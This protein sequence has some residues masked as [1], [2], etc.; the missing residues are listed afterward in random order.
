MRH[1][2]VMAQRTS[3]PIRVLLLLGNWTG[4]GAERVA[5]HLMKRLPP[6]WDVHL[7]L[8]HAG[9]AWLEEL[10]PA[11]VHMAPQAARRFRYD[12]PNTELF[13]CTTLLNGAL[14]G[15]RALRQM[16]R[17]IAPDVVVSFLK[18]TAIL[19]W[20]ALAGLRKRPGWIAREGNNIFAT[21]AQESPNRLVRTVSLG[22]TGMA[23][24][25]ADAV[26]TNAR[27]MA[28]D[29]TSRLRLDPARVHTIPNP[30]DAQ[31]IAAAA[32]QPLSQAPPR[33]FLLAVGRLEPQ[34]DHETLLAAFAASEARHTHELVILGQGSREAQLRAMAAALGVADRLSLV[35]F[36]ANPHAWMAQADLFV[37]PSRWEGFPNAAAEAAAAGAPLLL[38]DCPYG[39]REMIAP[40]IS[41]TLFPV[42][43]RGAL[44][45][46]IDRLL[47]DPALRARHR[48]AA[49]QR[50]RRFGIERIVA[51]YAELIAAVAEPQMAQVEAEALTLARA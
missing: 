21:A 41:G 33:P 48:A 32:A 8:L 18:G 34:K 9:T 4:G 44:A 6:H 40:G 2:T 7:G 43:D 42:G 20:L 37:M 27:I 45:G 24:R 10:D 50:V 23:Y 26:L 49:R 47:A 38:A 15:P 29:L 19:T 11:R 5:V 35:G 28:A 46:E 39:P 31:R 14:H 13:D 1:L 30:V 22:L 36:L 3:R 25:R 12:R 51:R 17:A 16:I